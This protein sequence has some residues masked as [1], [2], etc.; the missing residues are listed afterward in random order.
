MTP[1]PIPDFQAPSGPAEAEDWNGWAGKGWVDLQETLD[2]VFQP[3]ADFLVR[4]LEGAVHRVL[5][6]GSGTGATSLGVAEVLGR[7]GR[8]VGID[9]SEPMVEAARRRAE[10][11]NLPV[12]FLLGD[13]QTWTFEPASVEHFVS[14]FGVMFF[15]DPVQAFANLRR[16]AAADG[17]LSF[18]VWR[19]P[20]DNPFM[21]VA[22]RGASEILPD[23]SPPQPNAPGQFGLADP[24]RTAEVL[25][26]AGWRN[27]NI[28]AKDFAC[29]LPESQLL[30]FVTRLGV[31][32]RRWPDLDPSTREALLDAVIPGYAPFRE[33]GW[34]RVDAACWHLSATAP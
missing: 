3:Q 30:A 5:D 20:A 14:R 1:D 19:S 15:S 28:K 12:S 17:T 9:V 23:I 13:A 10:D 26:A 11:K 34:L 21:K 2:A 24:D 16:A 32:G 33:D 29:R 31:L 25:A 22:G 6:I 27:V 8:C 7:G 4:Q 18:L